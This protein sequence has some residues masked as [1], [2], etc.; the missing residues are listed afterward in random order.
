[1]SKA[2][3]N[4]A[5]T[6][7]P[8]A[9]DGYDEIFSIEIECWCHGLK[10]FNGTITPGLMHRVISE[11]APII[12]GA[13]LHD[14]IFNLLEISEQ[15]SQACKRVC[16]VREVAF[17][18]LLQLPAPIG[19][20]E[21]AQFILAQIIDQAE[22]T[23]GPVLFLLEEEWHKLRKASALDTGTQ[24]LPMRP[25]LSSKDHTGRIA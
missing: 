12:R 16:D 24:P 17:S 1:M 8:R 3:D 7:L 18:L 14:H 21:N 4:P 13:I 9:K 15:L 22:R 6:Q 10:Q 5:Q 2:A 25:G 23:F 19:L 11:L 20:E